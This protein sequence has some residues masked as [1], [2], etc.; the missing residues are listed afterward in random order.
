MLSDVHGYDSLPSRGATATPSGKR[1]PKTVP[2][3]PAA[4]CGHALF[5][6]SAQHACIAVGVSAELSAKRTMPQ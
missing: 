4:L 5:G 2:V 6:E 3:F 1:T